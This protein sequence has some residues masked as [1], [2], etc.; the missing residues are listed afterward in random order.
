MPA[1]VFV[2]GTSLSI[3]GGFILFLCMARRWKWVLVFATACLCVILY[4]HTQDP[5]LLQD[6]TTVNVST[7]EGFSHR[8][9]RWGMAFQAIRNEPI[10]GH[11]FGQ[12]LTYLTLIGSEGRA[13]DAYLTVWIELGIVGLFL[14]LVPIYQF[15]RAGFVLHRNPQFRLQG[16]LILSLTATLCLD[17]LGLSTLYWEKLPTIALSLALALIGMCERNG[18]KVASKE[19]G[20]FA[21]EPVVQRS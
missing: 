6:A 19:I 9:D 17:S 14:F 20:T 2:R 11:G 10:T 7:G 8:F 1:L 12:E 21:C 5:Q 16:A 15:F 18:S 4:L 3:V 13:H